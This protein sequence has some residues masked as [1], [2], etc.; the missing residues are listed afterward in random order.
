MPMPFRL[1]TEQDVRALVSAEDLVPCMEAALAAFSRGEV[2][3]PP[4][5]TLWVGTE[6]AFYGLMPAYL[7]ASGA[8]G[9]KLVTYFAANRARGLPSHFATI[10]LLDSCTG[11][12]VALMD[13][14][15]LTKIRTAAVSAVAVRHL[16]G[17]PVRRMAVF[18]CGTQARGHIATLSAVVPSLE[19]VRVWSP[20][21]ELPRFV[22]DMAARVRP[23]VRAAASGEDATRGADLVVTVTSSPDPVVADHWVDPGA[24][25]IAV[26]ACRPEHREIAPDLT[27]RS[28]V[29]VDSREA[30]FAE[31]GDVIQ[32]LAEGRFS[33]EHVAAEL[34]VVVAGT[35]PGRGGHEEVV[36]FKSLGLAVED[37]AAA[38]LVYQ[39]ALQRGAGAELSL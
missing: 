21:D 36:V 12:L 28:R 2:V 22:A 3:Q 11:A 27:A 5:S 38:E 39:R 8:L 9:T 6:R 19:D 23:A 32:G 30:A 31:S 37:V 10:V 16:A 1:L 34:G 7:P 4:R 24:L 26:G 17:R 20:Y 29:I 15:Y 14:S 18:G 35:K 13:G 25:V 33:R